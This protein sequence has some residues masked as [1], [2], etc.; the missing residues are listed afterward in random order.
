MHVRMQHGQLSRVMHIS[1]FPYFMLQTVIRC[2][3]HIGLL[4]RGTEKLIEYKT[5][6][7][8]IPLAMYMCK[9]IQAAFTMV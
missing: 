6:M 2:D 7:Q 3:P 5:Y 9:I 8:V 1:T 4:H